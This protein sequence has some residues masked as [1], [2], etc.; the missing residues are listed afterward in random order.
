MAFHKNII[1]A[2]KSNTFFRQVL[3]TA[4]NAQVVVMSILPGEDIGDEVHDLDQVLVFVEG[5][6]KAI[7]DGDEFNVGPGDLAYVPAGARHNFIN[8]GST[9]LKL[10][11]IY[12]PPEHADG[13]IHR[14]K[15]EAEA[16]EHH[17]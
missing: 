13:T 16:A 1:E 7:V 2:A 6:A 14:T 8:S 5:S 10:Y 15:A 9:P 3:H 11:T 12:A 17:E 4:N